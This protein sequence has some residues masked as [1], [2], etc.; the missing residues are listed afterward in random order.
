MTCSRLRI[1]VFVSLAYVTALLIVSCSHAPKHSACEE[2]LTQY[3]SQAR[4]HDEAFFALKSQPDQAMKTL[5]GLCDQNNLA[6][7]CSNAAH[8]YEN[9][10]TIESAPDFS[11]ARD[12]YQKGCD[13][14][15]G[16]ACHNL[17]NLFFLGRGTPPDDLEGVKYLEQACELDY[18]NACYRLA[19]ITLRGKVRKYDAAAAADLLRKGCDLG[20]T[21]SCHDL[22]Y[23]YLDGTG[24][25]RNGKI[26]LELFK[27]S[28]EQGLPRGCGSLG[29]LYMQGGSEGTDYAKAAELLQTAC[30]GDDAP[31]CSNLGYLIET[32]KGVSADPE[33]AAQYYSKACTGGNMM[34]CGNLGVLLAEGRG[35]PRDDL[36]AFP[37]LERGCSDS[38]PEACRY[39]AIFHEE[40]RAKLPRSEATAKYFRIKACEN[41]D[42]PSCAVLAKGFESL[43]KKN[44]NT[45][46]FCMTGEKQMVSLCM[47][48]T[49]G[50]AGKLAYRFGT[51]YKIDLTF[52]GDFH[53]ISDNWTNGESHKLIFAHGPAKYSLVETLDNSQDPP[54]KRVEIEVESDDKT[55]H[56]ACRYPIVGTLNSDGIRKAINLA[57]L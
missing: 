10:P 5:L 30:A 53:L 44:E 2:D 32:G 35:A 21:V 38:G 51:R 17:A 46:L 31:S 16:V 14:S 11:K 22:G 19:V 27:S 36:A 41:G 37:L 42:E 45:A 28:C 34:G 12:Y 24:V 9:P 43:C 26:A 39:V 47:S 52:T 15:D 23:L 7:A 1:A 6:R 33:R 20:D 40:G 56:I 55:T 50:N 3:D 25:E 18:A 8:S 48:K 49:K 29:S 54:R 57:P 13:L 4:C